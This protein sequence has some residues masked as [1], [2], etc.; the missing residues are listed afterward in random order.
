MRAA[1]QG[2]ETSQFHQFRVL[3]LG[4]QDK[5][6][7]QFYTYL[8]LPRERNIRP[9]YFLV[10]TGWFPREKKKDITIIYLHRGEGRLPREKDIITLYLLGVAGRSPR[11]KDIR[12]LDLQSVAGTLVVGRVGLAVIIPGILIGGV[13]SEKKEIHVLVNLEILL[14]A[15]LSTCPLS[16]VNVHILREYST[17]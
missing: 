9:L 12:I 7:T 14:I 1:C 8:L 10:V 16:E 5:R 17:L 11:D 4:S 6:I 3:Q 15:Y 2:K 13:Q